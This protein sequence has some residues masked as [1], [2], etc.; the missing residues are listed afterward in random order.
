MNN[1]TEMMAGTD[2]MEHNTNMAMEGSMGDHGMPMMDSGPV[3]FGMHLD[4][5]LMLASGVFYLIC[6]ISIF[7]TFRKEKNE[8]V[9][10]LFAFLVYQAI[11]MFFMGMEIHTMNMVY[12]NI[13]ALAIF[14]GTAYMLKFPLSSLSEKT[15]NISFMLI[16]IASLATFGWFMQTPDRQMDLMH[17]VIW[18]DVIANG[19]I[20]GGSILF[21][22]FKT[23]EDIAKRK[24]LGGG[25]GVMSCCI[26]ANVAMLTGFFFTSTIFAFLAPII[27]LFSLRKSAENNA[28]NTS[29]PQSANPA[30]TA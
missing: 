18:Y 25:V 20:V 2:M 12:S 14:V 11:S 22:G 29:V 19:I 9:G 13:A 23:V 3:Y 26:I 16:L 24:A 6:A 5:I 17:A 4:I 10:A 7:K 27:I 8:L 21:F 30:V 1:N 15:R 28:S